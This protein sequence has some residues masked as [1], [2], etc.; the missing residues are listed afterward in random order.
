MKVDVWLAHQFLFKYLHLLQR[1][2]V[3]EREGEGKVSHLVLGVAELVVELQH[4]LRLLLRLVEPVAD[5]LNYPPPFF[6]LSGHHFEHRLEA[7]AVQLGLVVEVL[8]VER[9]L[10]T[11]RHASHAE[12]E[13]GLVEVPLQKGRSVLLHP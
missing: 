8:E 5:F 4:E 6:L 11:L 10:L 13:P 1:F 7:L 12:V 9:E 2:F 3:T